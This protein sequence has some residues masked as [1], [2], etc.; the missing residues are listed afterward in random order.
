MK[1]LLKLSNN[2][3]TTRLRIVRR[4]SQILDHYLF[5]GIGGGGEFSYYRFVFRPC[6]SKDIEVRKDGRSIDLHI[7]LPL[8]GGGPIYFREVQTDGVSGP[9]G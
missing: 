4:A 2:F 7:K 9:R 8:I 1:G 6:S 3:Y 5:A